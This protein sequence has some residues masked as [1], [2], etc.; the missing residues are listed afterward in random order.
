MGLEMSVA[1]LHGKPAPNHLVRRTSS[2]EAL[3]VRAGSLKSAPL[4]SRARRLRRQRIG[5]M[6]LVALTLMLF[7]AAVALT[8]MRWRG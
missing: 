8:V 2:D 4:S 3:R 7:V 6:V 5:S 1:P